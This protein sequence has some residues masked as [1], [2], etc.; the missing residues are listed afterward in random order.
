M[1]DRRTPRPA[2]PHPALLPR[3][4]KKIMI[5]GAHL[6]P[7]EPEEEPLHLGVFRPEAGSRERLRQTLHSVL[8]SEMAERGRE[9]ED[10]EVGREG[11][12]LAPLS[13]VTISRNTRS[14]HSIHKA[15]HQHWLSAF[16]KIIKMLLAPSLGPTMHYSHLL[17]ITLCIATEWKLERRG[18]NSEDVCWPWAKCKKPL[19][20]INV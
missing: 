8:E 19:E 12:T 7:E 9:R 18:A 1:L 11:A 13:T 14:T 10:G 3:S 15:C 4:G 5:V 16:R 2:R 20:T 17:P 6:E